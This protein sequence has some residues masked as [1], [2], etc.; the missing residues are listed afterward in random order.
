[1]SALPTLFAVARAC[2][3]ARCGLAFGV[4]MVIH[5]AGFTSKICELDVR[6]VWALHALY[7]LGDVAALH[8][9]GPWSSWIPPDQVYYSPDKRCIFSVY[10]PKFSLNIRKN[11]S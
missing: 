3:A 10:S 11:L 1:M 8:S 7:A 4:D 5:V 9:F 2:F 6:A